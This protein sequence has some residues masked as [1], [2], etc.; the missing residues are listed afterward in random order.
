M[1]DEL[2]SQQGSLGKK[3]RGHYEYYGITGNSDAI[4]RFFQEAV[5]VWRKWLNRRSQNAK[6]TWERMHR[7]LE[8]YP[9]PPPR[10]AHP[11][12]IRPATH[13]VAPPLAAA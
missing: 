11:L 1:H 3:L 7:L 13:I 10:V 12:R 9:L 6:M 2:K 4:K 5:E 8:R